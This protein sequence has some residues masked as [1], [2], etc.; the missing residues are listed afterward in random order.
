MHMITLFNFFKTSDHYKQPVFKP[1]E[2]FYNLKIYDDF[3]YLSLK[4]VFKF[5]II[6]AST[7]YLDKL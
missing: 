1:K 6:L 3:K 4:L 2:T 5:I 7:R